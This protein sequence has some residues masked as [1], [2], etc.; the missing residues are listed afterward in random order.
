MV[1]RKVRTRQGV[2]ASARERDQETIRIVNNA[3]D[4]SQP[5]PVQLRKIAAV[6]GL[7]NS[8][9]RARAWPVLLGVD[10]CQLD[11]EEYEQL[12]SGS[13]RDTSV[14]KCDVARSLWSFTEGWS[15]EER[16][17][18]RHALQRV[19]TA[20]VC[21]H[22]GDV[23]YYQG[24][25]DVAAVLL[26]VLGERGAYL[27]LRQMV[28]AQLRDCT[29]A[30]MEPVMELLGL[31][32]PV[33]EQC[34]PELAQVVEHMGLPPMYALPWL[35]TLFAHNVA[36]LAQLSRLF[37]LFLSSHPLMPLYASAVVMKGARNEIMRHCRDPNQVHSLL[38]RLDVL[39][40]VGADELAQ[41]AVVLFKHAPPDVL[42]KVNRMPMYC[43]VLVDAY[44]ER[45]VWSVPHRPYLPGR[46]PI[47]IGEQILRAWQTL[48]GRPAK[49]QGRNG[50]VAAFTALSIPAL[51]MVMAAMMIMQSDRWMLR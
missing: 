35:I 45:D 43:A 6:R 9:V 1:R 3:L 24:M 7:V 15:D 27:C 8:E 42:V 50:K 2:E 49:P 30:G 23:Y 16:E 33:L 18:K 28:K 11:V 5:D 40:E 29:R 46:R 22:G 34:D 10:P 19:L 12:A 36:S 4:V 26:F 14:V 47:N 37:D 51:M 17:E 44:L 25:H 21:A 48:H 32:L 41:Q 20:A 13:H 31:L 38:M 39:R